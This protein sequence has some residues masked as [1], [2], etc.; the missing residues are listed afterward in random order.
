MDR[1]LGAAAQA[2]FTLAELLMAIA[3]AGLVGAGLTS[4]LSPLLQSHALSSRALNVQL[5]LAA[6]DSLVERELRQASLVL[7][8][9]LVGLP[10]DT[11]EGCANASLQGGTAVPVDASVPMRW[12]AFCA[13]QGLVYYHRGTGCSGPWTCGRSPAA[14]FRWGQSPTTVLSFARASTRDSLVTTY[15]KAV[16]SGYTAEARSAVAFASPASGAP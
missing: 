10:S 14:T 3:L 1:T 12:F 6:V 4:I 13:S 2:G 11:L 16:S 7:R 5:G 8:P 15:I 9:A